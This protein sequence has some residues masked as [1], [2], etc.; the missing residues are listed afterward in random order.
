MTSF[1]PA[2]S[3]TTRHACN[4]SIDQGGGK[5]RAVIDPQAG[6]LYSFNRARLP[7]LIESASSRYRAPA[8]GAQPFAFP[9][10]GVSLRVRERGKEPGKSELPCP[11]VAGPLRRLETAFRTQQDD[12]GR[13]YGH[14]WSF[15][16]QAP[17]RREGTLLLG[18]PFAAPTPL[19]ASPA[20]AH[21][22]VQ[23]VG[24]TSIV[25]P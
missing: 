13:P 5:R 2:L 17:E 16:L 24:F 14:R 1:C 8:P 7:S 6:P 25:K 9:Y 4:S 15:G 11:S 12:D 22:L 21:P 19:R 3:F 10:G 20:F 18:R 23:D